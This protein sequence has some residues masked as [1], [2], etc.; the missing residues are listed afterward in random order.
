M[1]P[2]GRVVGREDLVGRDEAVT[3]LTGRLARGG[4]SLIISGVRRTG[5]TSVAME[6]LRRLGEEGHLTAYVDVLAAPSLDDFTLAF[7]DAVLQNEVTLKRGLR[8]VADHLPS[9]TGLSVTFKDALEMAV[10]LRR[11]RRLGLGNALD[12]AEHLAAHRGRRLFVVMDEFQEIR[13][14]GSATFGVLRSHLQR[15]QHVTY[16]FLGSRRGLLNALFTKENEPFYRFA[17]FEELPEVPALTWAAYLEARFAADGKI[18]SHDAACRLVEE[19]G[20]HPGD[21]MILA[22]TLINNWEPAI[23][24]ATA[25]N[26]AVEAV[27]DRLQPAFAELWRLVGQMP[28]AQLVLARIARDA[29]VYGSEGRPSPHQ[30]SR[31]VDFLLNETIIYRERRGRYRFTERLFECYVAR[32]VG[33]TA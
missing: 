25:I 19:A 30:V 27:L 22:E 6:V 16:L 5:K 28:Y 9:V 26:F 10:D 14:F 21:L 32:M 2:V 20:G 15:Q 33:P 18:V 23:G 31:A 4:P 13:R 3:R 17:L 29:P 24:E 1:F 12:L 7:A 11:S 8:W